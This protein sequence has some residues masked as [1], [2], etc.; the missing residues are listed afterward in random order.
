MTWTIGA[1]VEIDGNSPQT[2]PTPGGSGGRLFVVHMTKDGSDDD[3][4]GPVTLGDWTLIGRTDEN[5]DFEIGIWTALA[6]SSPDMDFEADPGQEYSGLYCLRASH[7]TDASPTFH[8]GTDSGYTFSSGTQSPNDVTGCPTDNYDVINIMQ[9]AGAGAGGSWGA[10]TSLIDEDGEFTGSAWKLN[11]SINIAVE[12]DDASGA[13]YTPP[14][15]TDDGG[16]GNWVSSHWFVTVDSAV[17]TLDQYAYRGFNDDGNEAAA[18]TKAAEDTGFNVDAGDRFVL[19][20]GVDISGDLDADG[21][22]IEHQPPAGSW[23]EVE[24]EQ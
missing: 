9:G 2:V 14:D 21:F 17:P 19:R 3:G 12:E 24:V 7:L 16:T 13:T 4:Y 8:F 23:A 1:F 5:T 10:G 11:D 20:F 15:F 22:R 6:S 18:T